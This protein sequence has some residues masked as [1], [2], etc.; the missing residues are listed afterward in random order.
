MNCFQITGEIRVKRPKLTSE[1]FDLPEA[2]RLAQY[3]PK[4]VAQYLNS[5]NDG[6][7]LWKRIPTL[8]LHGIAVKLIP[9]L[10]VYLTL[11]YVLNIYGFNRL[12]CEDSYDSKN[13]TTTATTGAT[14]TT[15]NPHDTKLALSRGNLCDKA[16]LQHWITMERDFT[17]ILTFFIGFFVSLSVK[18]FF[19][20][21]R[22]VPH[23]DQI[24]I[25]MNNFLWVDPNKMIDDVHIKHDMT[26]KQFRNTI[27]RYFLLSWTLCLSRM[28]VRL[29]E[30][31]ADELVL[32]KKRLMLKREF[33]ILNCGTEGDSWREK[34]STPLA[35]I[36]KMVNDA[37]TNNNNN[38]DKS[39]T[40]ILDIKD[41]IGKTIGSFCQ[42]LQKLNSYNY[43]RIPAPLYQILQV[44]MHFFLII[45]SLSL[46][47]NTT[48]SV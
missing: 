48:F 36:A 43:Y 17:K 35:W 7:P 18:N 15:V 5:R 10:F 34:W 31:F 12:L 27:V 22:L 33:D 42:D 11:Y 25:Q 40:K 6:N 30:E 39:T 21:V 26:A 37:N 24:L 14:T 9:V 45:S 32:N 1:D 29:N 3:D 20:Q 23:L 38:I 19:D 28:S 13:S 41:A 8:L 2:D 44:S 16:H 47:T 4:R 46:L